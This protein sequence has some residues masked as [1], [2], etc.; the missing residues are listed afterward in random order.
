MNK[1]F[2]IFIYYIGISVSVAAP[3]AISTTSTFECMSLEWPWT[4]DLATATSSSVCTVEYRT[5]VGSGDWLPGLNAWADPNDSQFSG[6][7]VHLSPGTQ[8]EFRMTCDSPAVQTTATATTWSETFTEDA[9]KTTIGVQTSQYTITTAMDGASGVYEVFEN[10]SITSANPGGENILLVLNDNVEHVIIRNVTFT[11]GHENCIELG[12]NC[13]DIV[14]ENC[15]FSGWGQ[16]GI[17]D[18]S[19]FPD[20]LQ[21]SAIGTRTNESRVVRII[22]QNCTFNNDVSGSLDWTD[23]LNTDG[24]PMGVAQN[25]VIAFTGVTDEGGG[26]IGFTVANSDEA[27]MP[28]GDDDYA[29]RK[30]GV[31][32]LTGSA[33]YNQAHTASNYDNLYVVDTALTTS[34]K[35]VTTG[36]F[37]AA[38]T[39]NLQFDTTSHPIGTHAIFWGNAV[40]NHVIR[41]NVFN[42]S[43]NR[44]YNDT[45][46]G[47]QNQSDLYG[48]FGHST[49]IYGNYIG[50]S[51]D[52]A[53]EMEGSGKNCRV[54]FNVVHHH[55]A[56]MATSAIRTGPTYMW[57]NVIVECKAERENNIDSNTAWKCGNNT[58]GR[59]YVLFNNV[60]KQGSVNGYN[61]FL[62]NSNHPNGWD[63]CYSRNNIANID[64]ATYIVYDNGLNATH[65]F[66]YDLLSQAPN[67]TYLAT[68]NYG[69]GTQPPSGGVGYI[70]GTATYS[71]STSFPNTSVSELSVASAGYRA[72]VGIANFG[73]NASTRATL[74]DPDVGALDTRMV[75]FVYG[76]QAA[77]SGTLT[78][79]GTLTVGP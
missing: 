31:T 35:V 2:L 15:T 13:S 49:D 78:I 6:S 56:P 32:A 7:V 65:D 20:G 62:S 8:Y 34:T 57:R 60:E 58:L 17:A 30:F 52:N 45:I 54:W 47:Y 63:Y 44:M 55:Y 28:L 37:G 11:G 9:S 53:I 36:T 64:P 29:P 46:G 76:I 48:P 25:G 61:G 33:E 22:V 73:M 41:Y 77:A 79:T 66:Q 18:S 38:A 43:A 10:G 69:N 74:T 75:P 14:I 70:L 68:N 3:P 21:N 23:V 27:E 59:Q 51:L 1:I 26:K 24:K 50:W 4:A 42:G 72:G 16:P 12:A 67:Y 19:V 39:G 5:P 71:G 40:G